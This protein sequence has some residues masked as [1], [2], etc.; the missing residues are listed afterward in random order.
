MF[1]NI[2]GTNSFREVFIDGDG[3]GHYAYLPSIV[4]FQTVDF[5][6]A[7]EFEKSRRP[8][9]YMGHYFHKYGNIWINKY[10]SGTALLELPF[11]LLAFLISIIFGLTP[12][13]YNIIFQYCIASSALFWVGLGLIYLVK[14][15]TI[16]HIDRKTSW[17]MAGLTLFGTNLFCYTFIE[18]S[19]SHGYSFSMITIFLYYV[20]KLTTN[21]TRKNI[22]IAS[23]TLG[24]IVLIRPVNILIVIAIPFI[25]GSWSIF[26]ASIKNKLA[27]YD[28][29]I[30]IIVFMVAISPQFIINHMQT[31]HF[32][33]YGYANEG[34]YF[35]KPQFFNFLFSYQKGWLIY[36]PVF[37]FIFPSLVFLYGRVSKYQFFT[38]L[39]FLILLVYIFSSWWNW[40]YGDSF[41]MRPM[42]DYYGLLVLPI[43]LF[44]SQIKSHKW[45][46]I[47][48]IVFISFTILNIVQS[49]QYAV[50]IIHPDSMT[51]ESYWHVFL[52]TDRNLKGV[53][54]GSDETYYG[55]LSEEPFFKTSNQIEKSDHG[56]KNSVVYN[57]NIWYSDSL[58][59]EQTP[60][61]VYS[62]SYLYKIPDT[63]IGYQNIYVYFKSM[64]FE[65]YVDAAIDAVFVVDISNDLGDTVFYK[66][67]KLKRLPNEENEVWKA[68]S[69][70]FKLPKI[71]HE[72]VNVKFYIWN[73]NK[74]SYLLDDLSL[75]MWLYRS[76]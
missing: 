14:L 6:D 31:G 74:Q 7:F 5:E 4:L 1:V 24:L 68:G 45:K 28:F 67:F 65:N 43:S 55:R 75:E 13:G 39:I 46:L 66:T 15:L 61:L 21:Y 76:N 48:A 35:S 40:Y 62:P 42:I 72:M 29:L 20:R 19:F 59:V 22:I 47:T 63:L 52:K 56:W 71:T 57:N 2:L 12:D 33:I 54:A 26:L 60:E 16:Y 25:A 17:L 44:V 23:L 30:A 11:F 73:I 58:S 69:I 37:I 3:S 32:I 70:G 8:A 36:T 64:Y 53:I 50:G 49:Y 41:G 38:L 9:D 27:N 51:K 10:T 34:F 18:P